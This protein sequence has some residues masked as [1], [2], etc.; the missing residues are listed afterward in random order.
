MSR[1]I[2][3]AITEEWPNFTLEFTFNPRD[4]TLKD[5][6]DP[7]EVVIFEP[8]GGAIGTRWISGK[9]ESYVA[10]DEMR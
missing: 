6:F 10:V 3:K 1:N 4:S 9:R 5:R 2:H 7:D 8:R